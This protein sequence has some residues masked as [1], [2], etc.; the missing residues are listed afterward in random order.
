MPFRRPGRPTSR[1]ACGPAASTTTSTP[2]AAPPPPQFFE[3]MGN[4][5]FGDYFKAEAIRGRGSCSPA[6][7]A[8]TATAV[9]HRPRHRRRRRAAL[10]RRGRLPR[11]SGSS[12]STRT[13]SGRWATSA[14]AARAPRS[15]GTTARPS[16]RAP[17]RPTR[18]P[19]TAT[20]R[21]GTSCS[22]S[23]SGA[24]TA[25]RPAAQHQRRHRRRPGADAHRDQRP[26]TVWETDVLAGLV[27][28]AGVVTGSRLGV[29]ERTDIAL[30]VIADHTRTATFLVNDG[31]VPSNEDRGYVLRRIIRRAVRYAHLLGGDRI[32]TPT[33]VAR[34][35][36]PHGRR[37]SGARSP[38]H[39]RHRRDHPA[40]GGGVPAHAEAG[41]VLL[42]ARL[43]DLAPA[44]LSPATSP[45]TCTRPTASRSRSPRRW[46]RRP[47]SPSTATATPPPWPRPRRSPRPAPSRSTPT[48]TSS[49]SEVLERFGPT[50]FV[51]REEF[52]VKATVNACSATPTPA[53]SRSSSTAR[54]ST[55]R[56][57]ARSA[58][59]AGS[60]PTP[61]GRGARHHLRHARPAPP[62]G[63]GSSRAP[64]SRARGHRR[65]R[66]RPAR[67]HPPQPHR[68]PHP[69]LGAALGAGRHRQAAGVPGRPRSPAVRLRPVRRP[70]RADPADRGPRQPRDPGQQPG[71]ALRD[72]QGGGGRL[73][74]I[75]FFGDKYG[76]IVRV[77]EAGLHST[78]LCGG[79]HVRAL[80]DIGPLKI[81][82]EESIGSNLRRIEAVTGTGPVER[83]REAEDVLAA[84]AEALNV[85]VSEV[86][87]GAARSGPTSSRPPQ[88][89]R[90]RQAPARPPAAPAE[91]AAHAVDGVVVARVD[92]LP[93]G[94]PRPRRGRS[95]PP[96]HPGRRARP[97]RPTAAAPPWSRS[98]RDGP[99]RRRAHRRGGRRP[100]RAAAARVPIWPWPA[101]RT[102]PASTTPSPWSEALGL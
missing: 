5:S 6:P 73:G 70:D 62:P 50:E 29:D 45:S 18:P 43:A 94:H 80:G 27:A 31:V 67:R 59:P 83:L 47:A 22:C 66:R 30:K 44:P 46:P 99:A 4:W 85:S 40:R 55:P 25:A 88:G 84:A 20:S 75:A 35:R 12:A 19:R 98:T 10:D 32:V 49:L 95:G 17:V 57:A 64:S 96:G 92:G 48:P 90:R 81:V 82:K 91:L 28:T 23:T 52:E 71:A 9:G 11:P 56:P 51:G 65:H 58:T 8:S 24:P 37:L 41:R 77:L 34:L 101:A 102:P 33:L 86:V 53:R 16:V 76:D 7:S 61:A 79:T 2:S 42:E 72:H 68:H 78:E 21:S 14:R 26:Q 3:M 38:D 63:R 97:G 39:E 1:S 100:S 69:P 54:R 13:T 36:R 15:S 89:A 93:G 87:D 60:P 74:A